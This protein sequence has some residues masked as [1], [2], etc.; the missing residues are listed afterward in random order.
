MI[1]AVSLFRAHSRANEKI[2]EKHGYSVDSSNFEQLELFDQWIW[3]AQ[4][5]DPHEKLLANIWQE[6]LV[7]IAAGRKINKILLEKLKKV[8]PGE[9]EVL[10]EIHQNDSIRAK[11]KEQKFLLSSLMTNGVIE[12]TFFYFWQR[13]ALIL[14]ITFISILTIFFWLSYIKIPQLKESIYLLFV[15]AFVVSILLLASYIT[16]YAKYGYASFRL[17]WL[18]TELMKFAPSSL[19]KKDVGKS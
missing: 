7:E 9:A 4:E 12:K 2:K 5:V 16:R 10:L 11:S 17:S 1:N 15:A 19:S 18:G 3:G 14:G 13:C 8:S 6:L